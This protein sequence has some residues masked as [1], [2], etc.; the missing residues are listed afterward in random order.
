VVLRATDQRSKGAETITEVVKRVVGLPGE[1]IEGRDGR[2]YINGEEIDEK[3]LPIGVESK[4]FGPVVDPPDSY[5]VLGDN[6]QLSNDSTVFGPVASHE[7]VGRIA[8]PV[9]DKG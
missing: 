8:S 7:V 1:T 6:R 3:Y 4:T 2:V 5:F 9:R